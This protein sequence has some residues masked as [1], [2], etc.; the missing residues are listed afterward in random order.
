MKKLDPKEVYNDLPDLDS[1]LEFAFRVRVDI[2]CAMN[3][4]SAND[5]TPQAYVELGWTEYKGTSPQ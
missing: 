3:V 5:L 1:N 4:P 2:R